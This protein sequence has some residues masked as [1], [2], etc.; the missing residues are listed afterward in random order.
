MDLASAM[1]PSQD[2][3]NYEI[4]VVIKIFKTYRGG[5]KI[6]VQNQL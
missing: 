3:G 2:N 6:K 5:E 4:K 1:F